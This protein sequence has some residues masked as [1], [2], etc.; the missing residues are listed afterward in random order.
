MSAKKRKCQWDDVDF[1]W[2][3][4]ERPACE[5]LCKCPFTD[6]YYVEEYYSDSD[7][8]DEDYDADGYDE[9]GY[10]RDGHH[11]DDAV[12]LDGPQLL[13]ALQLAEAA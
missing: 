7:Y 3:G 10:H 5:L 2:F 11:R 4:D 6:A 9:F 8:Y 12:D 1:D 13:N